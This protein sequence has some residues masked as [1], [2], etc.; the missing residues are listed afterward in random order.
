[1]LTERRLACIFGFAN[2]STSVVV[3]SQPRALRVEGMSVAAK[4]TSASVAGSAAEMG[5][6][7]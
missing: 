1:L 6:V 7:F 3:A 4:A 2:V 5:V